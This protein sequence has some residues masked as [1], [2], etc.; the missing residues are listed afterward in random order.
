M[1]QDERAEVTPES[2]FIPPEARDEEQ[3][4]EDA[5]PRNYQRLL[6]DLYRSD[7]Y[8]EQVI[9][10]WAKFTYEFAV[11]SVPIGVVVGLGLVCQRLGLVTYGYQH[12]LSWGAG[13]AVSITF[14]GWCMSE[15]DR[16]APS[17]RST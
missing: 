12:I 11:K 10:F 17:E 13:I 5:Q 14:V 7:R 4:A 15:G 1:D 6:N 2:P 16:S 9:G 8:H 3:R